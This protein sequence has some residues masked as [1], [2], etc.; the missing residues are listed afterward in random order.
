MEM[1]KRKVGK[2]NNQS[3]QRKLTEE[4]IRLLTSDPN[5]PVEEDE[6]LRKILEPF[7]FWPLEVRRRWAEE[8]REE[9]RRSK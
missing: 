3:K 7:R 2:G 6:W 1:P 9:H 4:Q 8:W 5:E